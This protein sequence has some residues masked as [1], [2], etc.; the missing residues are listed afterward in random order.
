MLR[1]RE[2]HNQQQRS[3]RR[4]VRARQSDEVR[5]QHAI[6]RRQQR[7]HLSFVNIERAGFRY[8]PNIQYS[9]SVQI[10]QMSVVCQYCNA[11]KFK[12]EPSGLCCA[13]GKVKLPELL[14]PPQPLF[15]LL[16]GHFLK[17]TKMY[18]DSFQMTSFGGEIVN[19]QNYN[20]T[21]KVHGQIF[22]LAGSLLPHPD[23][24]HKYLQI[25]FLGDS[26]DEV[27]RRCAIFNTTNTMASLNCLRFRW[28]VCQQVIIV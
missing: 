27:N 21:F 26:N 22:H 13:G 5:S 4:E 25:Y 2:V 10:G 3:R 14:P 6:I 20:P 12:N 16:Y 24:E 8:D 11:V 15:P 19:E 1:R 9:A 28:H 18:N 23:Q 7:Q 17:H